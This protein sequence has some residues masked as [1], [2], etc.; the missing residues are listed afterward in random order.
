VE[1]TRDLHCHSEMMDN[2]IDNGILFNGWPTPVNS[3]C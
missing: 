2:R 1:A 3:N